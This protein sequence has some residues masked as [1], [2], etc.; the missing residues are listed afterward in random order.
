M[1][2]FIVKV[3]L[4]Y[5]LYRDEF[6]RQFVHAQADF[7]KSTSTKHFTRTIE[8]WF[9]FRR[10]ASL[11]KVVDD[12]FCLMNHFSN[13]RTRPFLASLG[14]SLYIFTVKILRVLLCDYFNR[15]FP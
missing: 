3:A 6:A 14:V 1:L 4:I 8:L 7:S 5:A 12:D 9:G 2:L 13:A 10:Y 15:Q 11:F